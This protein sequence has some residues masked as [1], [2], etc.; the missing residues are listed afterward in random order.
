MSIKLLAFYIHSHVS[1]KW[2]LHVADS[3]RNLY[4]KSL[5]RQTI[6]VTLKSQHL[7]AVLLLLLLLLLLPPPLEHENCHQPLYTRICSSIKL[8][9]A[10]K[11]GFACL[12]PA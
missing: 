12:S 4:G 5:P 7:Y 10:V 3:D 2:N 8:F 9:V 1:V 6:E 11:G